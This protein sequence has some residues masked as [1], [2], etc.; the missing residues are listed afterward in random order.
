MDPIPE[1]ALSKEMDGRLETVGDNKSLGEADQDVND[2]NSFKKLL[3]EA[4]S[5]K[6]KYLN[7]KAIRIE[8]A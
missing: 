7:T 4:N 8:N 5:S 1:S 3:W 6:K 2:N